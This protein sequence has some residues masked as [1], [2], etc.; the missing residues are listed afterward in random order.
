[1]NQWITSLHRLRYADSGFLSAEANSI[2]ARRIARTLCCPANN[3]LQ[4]LA[5]RT[6]ATALAPA[7]DND[8]TAAAQPV[9]LQSAR[10][11]GR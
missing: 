1:L 3:L 2:I 8:R 4:A 9:S 5:L 6:A 7:D 10:H 11:I